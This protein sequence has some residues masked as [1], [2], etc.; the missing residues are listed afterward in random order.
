MKN[1]CGF[2]FLGAR[3]KSQGFHHSVLLGSIAHYQIDAAAAVAVSAAGVMALTNLGAAAQSI[4]AGLTNPAVPRCLSVV[5]SVA[6]VTTKVT[7]HGTNFADEDISEEFTLNGVTT[8]NGSKAFRTITKVD[9]P[10]QTHVP[11][12]QTETQEYTHKADAAGTITVAVTAAALGDASPKSVALEVAL[13]DTAV[14]VATKVVAALNAD[15]D[16]K[17]HFVASNLNGASATVTLTA[18]V[19][20]A[21][22]T[23]L[24][25][26]FTDTD[27]TG[28]TAG[29]STNGNAGV[30]YDKVSVGWNDKLGLPFLLDHNTVLAAY[31]NKTKE[32]SA[33]T[34]T[35]S[36][37]ALES[38]TL[39][40]D[41]ALAGTRVDLYFIV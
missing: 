39:D 27:T 8:V 34:V 32:S 6:G 12:L 3:L 41:S 18:K 29:S 37:T 35:V 7:V 30:Q 10:V 36:A 5:A 14:Q 31:V 21:N 9:L 26:G 33:P 38:N 24:A 25:M 2:D 16:V 28:V 4:I 11:V 17:A 1:R 15:D 19:P 22:D 20:A 13:D 23:T 40:L